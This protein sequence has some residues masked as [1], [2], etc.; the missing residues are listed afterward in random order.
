MKSKLRSNIPNLLLMIKP[1]HFGFNSET[2]ISNHFQKNPKIDKLQALVE[3]TFENVLKVFDQNEIEY[4]IFE[5]KEES[6]PD[7]VFSNNWISSIMNSLRKMG[8]ETAFRRSF[9]SSD[10]PPKK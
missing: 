1:K 4:K 6:S 2:A 10:V 9:K 8:I 5:D 7:A 3:N